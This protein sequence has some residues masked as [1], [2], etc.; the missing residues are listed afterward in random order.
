LTVTEPS[1]AARQGTVLAIDV[2]GTKLAVGIVGHDGRVLER[3]RTP[4]PAGAGVDAETIWSALETA[5]SALPGVERVTAVGV[6]C[7]GP[8]S[9]PAGRVSPLN[10]PAWRE[11][12]L[13][14]RLQERFPDV[15]VRLHND[16]VCFVAAEHWQGAGVG[17]DNMLGMVVSTGVGGGVVLGGRLIDGH[18]GNAGHVG[19][20]VVDPSGPPCT[21]GGRG[22]LE[23]IARGP[24]VVAWAVQ[25]GWRPSGDGSASALAADARVGDRVAVA[26]FERAGRAVGIA[27]ASTAALLDVALVV[28]G[29]GLIQ[30]GE[31]LFGPIRVALQSHAQMD[32]V[33]DLRVVP[34]ELGQDAGLVGAAALVLEGERYWSASG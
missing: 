19:H 11:F 33:R 24:A 30:T 4:T 8:M 27:L 6:G 23:A 7:G 16:A 29:G 34:A 22:C 26:A 20:V 12:P 5:V 3:S 2:G 14:Q 21:C 15:S 17:V 10:I 1:A 28:V 18:T 25:N 9:W 32:F 13:R 31:L